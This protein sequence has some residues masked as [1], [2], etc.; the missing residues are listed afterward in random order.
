MSSVG[1]IM[2]SRRHA[3]NNNEEIYPMPSDNEEQDREAV[4]FKM[5]L[6]IMDNEIVQA[7]IGD[8]PQK[9]IDMGTGIGSWAIAGENS[10]L[11]QMSAFP[12][13]NTALQSR[14]STQVPR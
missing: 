3:A 7:P 12:G 1:L 4:K 5:Y 13:A 2:R 10:R 8:H 9:I 14:T 6:E 11:D